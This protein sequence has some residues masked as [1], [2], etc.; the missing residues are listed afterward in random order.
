MTHGDGRRVEDLRM[1]SGR[2]QQSIVSRQNVNGDVCGIIDVTTNAAFSLY[3]ASAIIAAYAPSHHHHYML[4]RTCRAAAALRASL[5]YRSHALSLPRTL[6][7]RALC[8]LA[9]ARDIAKQYGA[10]IAHRLRACG[11]SRVAPSRS[12]SSIENASAR[13]R[14]HRQRGNACVSAHARACDMKRSRVS[15]SK[16]LAL[17]YQA[18]ICALNA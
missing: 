16:P 5:C 15:I 8:R 10:I 17:A 13:W 11:K 6:K 4:A 3:H 7:H 2:R 1:T 9:L 14:H 18:R 12:I